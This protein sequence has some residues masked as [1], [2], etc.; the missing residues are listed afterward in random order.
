MAKLSASAAKM[1]AELAALL[2]QENGAFET[3]R[4]EY[5]HLAAQDAT[6]ARQGVDALR[7]H[8]E[9]I[10]DA[11]LRRDVAK[12]NAGDLRE[13]LAEAQLREAEDAR[14]LRYDAHVKG[15]DARQKKFRENVAAAYDTLFT[16]LEAAKAEQDETDAINRDLPKGAAH[17]EHF[18]ASWR[19]TPAV[20]DREEIV[21]RERKIDSGN[22]HLRPGEPD[23]CPTETIREKLIVRGTP[24]RRPP[25]LWEVIELPGLDNPHLARRV[26]GTL[27]PS[28]AA[29]FG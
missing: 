16:T 13:R 18:E 27:M 26:P 14:Q 4:A 15:R 6:I 3:A 19:H 8:R 24:A 28:V 23:R 7:R 12:A 21:A 20:P 1:A 25:P 10:S 5:D 22:V 29:R 17:I 9:L 2:D 11:E